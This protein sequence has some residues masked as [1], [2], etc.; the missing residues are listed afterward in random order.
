M[1]DCEPLASFPASDRERKNTNL[2]SI[3]ITHFRFI[4]KSTHESGWASSLGAKLRLVS[5]TVPV[6]TAHPGT[7]IG[8]REYR[9]VRRE[10]VRDSKG[11]SHPHAAKIKLHRPG[12]AFLWQTAKYLPLG[13]WSPPHSRRPMLGQRLLQRHD[14]EVTAPDMPDRNK[15]LSGKKKK[16]QSASVAWPFSFFSGQSERH[17]LPGRLTRPE[18]Q[19][20]V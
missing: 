11:L 13:S 17:Q 1:H 2:T 6:S 10:K 8:K 3:I 5:R 7:A 15:R 14:T 4:I 18:T 19:E 12:I 20:V 16:S 9:E